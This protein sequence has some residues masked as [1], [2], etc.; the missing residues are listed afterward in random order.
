MHCVS[1]T[2]STLK[3]PVIIAEYFAEQ[4][5]PSHAAART[6]DP[7][8]LS[9]MRKT[10][11]SPSGSPLAAKVL[12][13][14][15]LVRITY[16]FVTRPRVFISSDKNTPLVQVERGFLEEQDWA[17]VQSCFV[18]HPQLLEMDNSASLDSGSF[19]GTRG[20]VVKFNKDGLDRFLTHDVY[21]CF[22]NVFQR[23][24]HPDSNAWVFNALLCP[25]QTEADVRENTLAVGLHVD[26]TIAID[27]HHD[28]F[29]HSVEVLYL[30]VAPDM[31]GG[32][33][34]LWPYGAIKGFGS[35]AKKGDPEEV[36]V[37]TVNTHVSFRGDAL[38]QVKSFYTASGTGIPRISLVLEQYR[39]DK[40]WAGKTEAWVEE[41]KTA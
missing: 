22:R 34:E 16:R 17:E 32:Q 6:R 41:I 1:D 29:A 14:I 25:E 23:L 5:S 39:V 3:I 7:S 31:I 20:F 10:S 19:A 24:R 15:V 38:H 13:A 37:P 33:L 40:A 8:K 9:S 26:Q 30:Q 28:F 11:P 2:L 18:K 36:V 21:G 4:K 12:I 35:V 27:S